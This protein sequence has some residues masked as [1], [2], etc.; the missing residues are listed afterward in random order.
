M[1][2]EI[3]DREAIALMAISGRISG[4]DNGP[5]GSFSA[6]ARRVAGEIEPN[7]CLMQAPFEIAETYMGDDWQV[8]GDIEI[9]RKRE[10]VEITNLDQGRVW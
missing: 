8:S 4:P 7:K 5:R 3:T 10:S 9:G 6:L 2:I 1:K